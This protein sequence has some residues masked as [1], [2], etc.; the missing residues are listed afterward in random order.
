MRRARGDV[1]HDVEHR[2]LEDGAQARAR[3]LPRSSACGPPRRA[4]LVNFSFTPSISKSFWYCL[5]QAVLGLVRMSMRA[6]SLSS[7]S[8]ATT[9]RRPMN[10]GMRPNLSRSSGCTCASS[11]PSFISFLLVTSAP[12]PR[13]LLPDAALDDLIEADEGAAAD[14][15]DVGRVD[16]QEVLLRVLAAALGRHVGDGALDD[17]E[18]RLLHALARHVARDAR[19]V[20]LAADLVDLV[21]VDDAALRPLDVVIG[22]LQQLHDDVLDVLAD[23]A[24]LGQRG[25]VGDGEGHVEDLRE[26]LRE[27]RLARARGAEQQDVDFCSSTSSRATLLASMRL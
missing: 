13:V 7:C 14:E 15:E 12:K 8:V 6:S 27:Q 9:G 18:Q 16:L 26:R 1:V 5:H 24:R 19:V 11:S 4:R 20:A 3:P 21:D 2:V 10:S 23:V 17:L 25:G 22:V